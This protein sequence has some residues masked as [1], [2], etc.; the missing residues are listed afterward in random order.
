ME[1]STVFP[2]GAKEARGYDIKSFLTEIPVGLSWWRHD[3]SLKT[4]RR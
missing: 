4:F 2:H 1:S 3:W